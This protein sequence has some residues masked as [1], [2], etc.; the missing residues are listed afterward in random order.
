[1]SDERMSDERMSDERMSD[2]RM[3][4]ERMSDERMSDERMS[5]E[6][7]V[8]ARMLD[9]RMNSGVTRNRVYSMRNP[10]TVFF[11]DDCIRKRRS[12]LATQERLLVR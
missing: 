2:E 8:V 7:M 11:P 10:P 9:E 5:E 3:S 1:M 12:N 6:R 4:D